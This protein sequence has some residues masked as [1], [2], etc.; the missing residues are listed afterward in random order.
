MSLKTLFKT[1]K[2]EGFLIP[3][4]DKHLLNASLGKDDDRGH[5]WNSP[6]QVGKCIRANYFARVGITDDDVIQP[7]LQRIFDNGH[8][9]HARIQ[10]YLLK[11]GVLLKDECPVYDPELQIMGHTDGI[12]KRS[13]LKLAIL[14]IKSENDANFKKRIAAEPE[15]ITQAQVYMMTL[16]KLR[17]KL[18]KCKN[19]LQFNSFKKKYL[20]EYKKFMETF[21][22][23]GRKFTKEEKINFKLQTMSG[24]M[25]ILWN[26]TEPINEIIV[27]YE[28]K[29]DQELK[30][31]S[32]AWDDELVAE[33]TDFYKE[34]NKYV[35]EK[36]PP[37][38]PAEATGKNCTLC[39]RCIKKIACWN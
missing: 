19:K 16:E 26:C 10:G 30:E 31:Y 20:A 25:D 13:E 15:H 28:D 8:G 37:P 24:V 36:T 1:F 23:G 35:A 22:T 27:L 17:K 21:V 39:V 3:L 32:V 33:I 7:R 4:I 6:S 5:G 29:N 11:I 34:L 2:N 14:E 38:R 9:V 18:Q 12:L